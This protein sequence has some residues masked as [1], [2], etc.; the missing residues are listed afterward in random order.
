MVS[1]VQRDVQSRNTDE[2]ISYEMLWANNGVTP[3]K[4][5]SLF[6]DNALPSQLINNDLLNIGQHVKELRQEITKY[7]VPKLD[8][9][10]ININERAQYPQCVQHPKAPLKFFYYKGNIELLNKPNNLIGISGSRKASECGI[11]RTTQLVR[12]LTSANFTIVSGLAKGID[13][14]AHT[15]SIK[16]GGKTIA[17]LGTPIDQ[18]HHKKNKELQDEIA[19]E[20]LLISHVP[21]YKYQNESFQ[22]HSFYFPQRNKVIASVS[23]AVVIV[24]AADRSGSVIQARETLKQGKKLFILNSCFQNPDNTWAEKLEGEANV[25]RVNSTSDITD[26]L[27]SDAA[28][29]FLLTP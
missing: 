6:R 9:L 21:F 20:H 2:I 24:E 4:L 15:T 27:S 25:F 3:A 1:V 28:D 5:A 29:S 7:M 26:N 23:S 16:D 19:K 14:A 17:I 8:S 12:D 18:Y 13:T 10:S 11:K 22:N